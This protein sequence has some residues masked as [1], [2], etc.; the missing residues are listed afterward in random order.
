MDRWACRQSWDENLFY[1][2]VFYRW[3]FPAFY[4]EYDEIKCAS[5]NYSCHTFERKKKS[6]ANRGKN[7]LVKDYKNLC[8]RSLKYHLFI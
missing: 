4:Q 5:S 2:V 6:Q 1:R 7:Q 8:S 3:F